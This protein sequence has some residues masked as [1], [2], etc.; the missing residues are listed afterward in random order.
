MDFK[1]FNIRVDDALKDMADRIDELDHDELDISEGDGK[2]VIEV[3]DGTPY[4]INRQSAS[5]QIWLAEPGGGW[6][7]IYKEGQ[8]RCDKRGLSLVQAVEEALS[9]KFGTK[10][11][12]S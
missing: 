6:H 12:L 9:K 5:N 11:S 2:L 3:D 1:D 4:I 7:F 8:W 10:I